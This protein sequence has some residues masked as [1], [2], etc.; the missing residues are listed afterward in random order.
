[1]HNYNSNSYRA[2]TV[3]FFSMAHE[4]INM[5][6]LFWQLVWTNRFKNCKA[7]VLTYKW[8]YVCLYHHSTKLRITIHYLDA[9]DPQ[10]SKVG[11]A[12]FPS[13][14]IIVLSMGENN[15]EQEKTIVTKLFNLMT[16][17]CCYFSVFLNGWYQLR[18][19]KPVILKIIL[20]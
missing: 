9:N 14:P 10:R 19:P 2:V 5:T 1:M 20:W 4:F 8:C 3:V 12:C 7:N 15:S 13:V 17:R 6:G 11:V 18:F 16:D